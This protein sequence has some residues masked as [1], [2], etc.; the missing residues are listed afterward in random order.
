[1][2]VLSL[3]LGGA[4]LLLVVWIA[5]LHVKRQW[6]YH[7]LVMLV[8][9]T[10]DAML[11]LDPGGRIAFWNQGAERMF[12]YSREEILGRDYR[13]LLPERLRK[14]SERMLRQ[15]HRTGEGAETGMLREATAL[16]KDGTELPVD[17]AASAVR[18]GKRKHTIAIV[19]DLSERDLRD[20]ELRRAKEHAEQMASELAA[21]NTVL[22][23]TTV[24]ANEMAAQA[25]MANAA[26]SEF[27]ASMSHEIRT[28]M[29]GVLGM[30]TLLEQT[31]LT[32]EQLDCV[33]TIRYSGQTL[34]DIINQIL[35]FSKVESGKLDLEQ[36]EFEPRTEVEQAVVLFAEKAQSKG[37]ELV[38]IVASEVPE[39][40]IGD[41]GRF[42]Q[43]LINLLGN[44]MKFTAEGSV[45]VEVAAGQI[46]DRRV[47]LRV[48][49]R[50]T[51]IGM[52]PEV[53]KKLFRPFYQGDGSTRR[54]YGGTGL[55]LAISKRLI[56]AMQGAIEVTSVQG[57]G[58]CF[59]F[60][61]KAGVPAKLP[62]K[63]VLLV[64]LTGARALL[65]HRQAAVRRMLAY[66]TGVWGMMA[67]EAADAAAAAGE[68]GSV[69]LVIAAASAPDL[70]QLKRE[71]ATRGTN[72]AKPGLVLL[73][74]HGDR[75]TKEETGADALVT[76]PVR[77][78]RLREA[79]LLATGSA[80]PEAS[81]AGL[82]GATGFQDGAP[83]VTG[84]ILVAEDNL[85]NQKVARRLLEKLGYAVEIVE[86]GERAVTALKTGE[87]S[88]VLMDSQMPVMDGLAATRAIR[89]LE[90]PASE[91]PIIA[92]T[93]AAMKGDREKCLEAGMSDYIAKPVN[94]DELKAALSRWSGKRH[95][96]TLP[97]AS[98]AEWEIDP[99]DARFQ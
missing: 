1:M 6:S 4:A 53:V 19:R 72:G 37:V 43:I 83:A 93:A 52:A 85:V 97:A 13:E 56:E 96:V 41:P 30:L 28:P 9:A 92:M 36:I 42:R 55:G 5:A 23:Q 35:D 12:G 16:R 73:T 33:E 61:L 64:E 48:D 75:R 70:E 44:A 25:A 98:D 74:P 88:V 38:S 47:E 21:V 67:V 91:I 62:K 66:Y 20:E 90:G 57:Q 3:I 10:H 39:R 76:Q 2:L 7:R 68:L 31:E 59:H 49:V 11:V 94:L 99:A 40:L 32:R 80:S 79:L 84:K 50:D 87:Y 63:P 77:E 60:T 15:V 65:I 27:L 22:E 82:A 26:K 8:A 81:L 18:S 58:S 34:L 14:A 54:K 89:R 51:G 24:W 46:E 69:R 45:T 95:N 78:S 71:L 17:I 29:N 86:N